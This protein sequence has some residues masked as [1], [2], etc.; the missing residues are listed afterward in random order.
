LTTTS[1]E[2]TTAPLPPTSPK[3]LRG[4]WTARQ[5]RLPDPPSPPVGRP[6][7]TLLPDLHT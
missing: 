2:I 3:V 4:P 6:R 5:A 7:L 1:I